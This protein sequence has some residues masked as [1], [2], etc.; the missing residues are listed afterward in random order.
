MDL[1]AVQNYQAHICI[2]NRKTRRRNT[3]ELMNGDEHG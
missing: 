1:A 2:F 3:K